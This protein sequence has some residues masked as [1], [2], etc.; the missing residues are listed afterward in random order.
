MQESLGNK[1]KEAVE[2]TK[3]KF[4]I[5]DKTWYSDD[6]IEE[7][8]S[9]IKRELLDKNKDHFYTTNA[10]FNRL[11]FPEKMHRSVQQRLQSTFSKKGLERG[12]K[13]I[14]RSLKSPYYGTSDLCPISRKCYK[15]WCIEKEISYKN[16]DVRK[17]CPRNEGELIFIEE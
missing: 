7:A 12:I 17:V 2:R 3:K 14:H 5:D 6:D 13:K 4:I 9:F 10:I 15:Q 16:G 8:I 11:D 1:I